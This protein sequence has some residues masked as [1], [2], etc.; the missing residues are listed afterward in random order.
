MSS[1]PFLITL[2]Y[3]RTKTGDQ[4]LPLDLYIG[5]TAVVQG[6]GLA[7]VILV[8]L[9][10][11]ALFLAKPNS[12]DRNGIGIEMSVSRVSRASSL[13]GACV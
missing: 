2:L 5:V 3:G 6:V 9:T 1:L 11:G 12:S 10:R 13:P 4:I 8:F 7:D